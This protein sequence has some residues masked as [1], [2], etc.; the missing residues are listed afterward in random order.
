MPH[1]QVAELFTLDALYMSGKGSVSGLLEN[2]Y[3]AT[4][5]YKYMVVPV[6][7]VCRGRL[8]ARY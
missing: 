7:K 6:W 2:G 5:Q 8:V 4:P 1:R 3:L